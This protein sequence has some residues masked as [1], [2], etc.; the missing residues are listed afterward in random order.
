M[1][2][3]DIS[4]TIAGAGF[5]VLVLTAWTSLATTQRG[6][7][8]STVDDLIEYFRS[9]PFE[10]ELRFES[11]QRLEVGDLV[12]VEG[13]ERPV[14]EL[15]ALLDEAGNT[16][17]E[18]TSSVRRARVRIWD[19][20]R[21]TPRVG[22]TATLERVPDIAGRWVVETL[23]PPEKL[24]RIRAEWLAAWN[25]EKPE[26]LRRWMP[27]LVL[28]VDEIERAAKERTPEFFQRH[29]GELDDLLRR[30]EAG[31]PTDRLLEVFDAVVWPAFRRH[32]DPI[33]DGLGREIWH[34]FPLWSMSWR[35]AWQS[36]PLTRDDHLER[37]WTRFLETEIIPLIRSKT[38]DFLDAAKHAAKDSLRDERSA[39]LLRGL[40]LRLFEDEGFQRLTDAWA[41]EVFLENE[42]LRRRLIDLWNSEPV[43]AEVQWIAG[44]FESIA[45]RITDLV[46]GSQES[47][48]SAEFAR[49]LRAQI[50]WKGNQRV[51]LSRTDESQPP[52]AEGTLL[53]TIVVDEDPRT[54]RARETGSVLSVD[55]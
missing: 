24:E 31:I 40:M 29:R 37:R 18:L 48:I 54:R 32:F 46:I 35:F 7:S 20:R 17:E 12:L 19:R 11:P 6:G 21:S 28:V 39:L 16:L 45:R 22:T 51:V 14:G 25:V 2:R 30:L 10:L 15:S 8:S 36:L 50:F 38:T 49:V 4:R 53:D 1:S 27:I 9:E 3:A 43:Q 52:L 42:T 5:W 47:G 55:E 13:R 44:R 34:R 26:V 33:T 41:R 23:A